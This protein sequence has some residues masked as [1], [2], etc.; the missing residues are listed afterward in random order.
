[1]VCHGQDSRLTGATEADVLC[2][3]IPGRL[4]DRLNSRTTR[5]DRRGGGTNAHYEG[6]RRALARKPDDTG[7]SRIEKLRTK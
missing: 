7:S 5:M 2:K 3:L 4:T 6:S 1:M